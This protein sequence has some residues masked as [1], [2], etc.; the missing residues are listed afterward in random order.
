MEPVNEFL[1]AGGEAVRDCVAHQLAGAGELRFGEVRSTSQDGADHLVEDVCAPVGAEHPGGGEP[2]EEVSQPGWVQDARVVGCIERHA[3]LPGSLVV[4][5]ETLG[6]GGELVGDG[7]PVGVVDALVCKEVGE[8]DAAT[9]ADASVGELA[10]LEE[11]H[12]VRP[13]DV[14]DVG[15]LLGGEFGVDGCDGHGVAVGDLGEDVDQQS[16]GVA[17]DL[18]GGVGVVGVERDGDA[19]KVGV[20]AKEPFEDVDGFS[21]LV[22][23]GFVGSGRSGLARWHQLLRPQAGDDRRDAGSQRAV[24]RPVRIGRAHPLHGVP[25]LRT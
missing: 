23:C 14:Q 13:G 5:A 10:F 15:G 4:Q 17:G 18:Q 6:L 9:V 22:G 24:A 8:Q 7:S 1:V 16:Q 3:R 12:Q 25:G 11:L 20:L 19:G 21:S 2:D